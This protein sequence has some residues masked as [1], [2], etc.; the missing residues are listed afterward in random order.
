MTSPA[1]LRARGHEV[2]VFTATPG[3]AAQRH[4]FVEVVDGV[5][6]HRMAL[7]LPWELPVNPLRAARGAATAA[8]WRVR[9]RPRAHGGGEP[10]RHRPGR[11]RAGARAADRHHLALPDG[12]LATRC[13]AP[14]ATPAAGEPGVRRC[15][16]S[17]V[18]RRPP[19]R[20]VVGAAARCGCFPTASTRPRWR[21]R[22]GPARAA[23]APVEVR[24]GHAVRGAQAPLG[25]PRG[26]APGR[27]SSSRPRRGGAARRCA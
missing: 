1:Q 17:P 15:P 22:R 10:V 8:G 25:R 7:R 23:D 16:R 21:R 11:G 14:S 13:S 9:R 27:G 24:G 4:G 18:S 12:A 26:R 2:E 6:V 5:P 3:A 20:R 19:C